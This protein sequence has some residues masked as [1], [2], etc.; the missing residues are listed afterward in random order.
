MRPRVYLSGPICGKTYEGASNWRN[1]AK[2]ILHADYGIDALDPMRATEAIRHLEGPLK[3][4]PMKH[5]VL[6]DAF[7]NQRD[8]MDVKNCDAMLV[9]LGDAEQ[10]SIGTMMEIG[11]AYALQKPMVCVL[12]PIHDHPMVRDACRVLAKDLEEALVV[13]GAMLN[14]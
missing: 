4:V 8:F 12:D 11:F 10:I 5:V 13:I 6:S 3:P 1:R 7:I 2:S 14:L 9:Y